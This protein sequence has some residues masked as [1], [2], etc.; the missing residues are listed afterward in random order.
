MKSKGQAGF[1]LSMAT[2]SSPPTESRYMAALMCTVG[3]LFVETFDFPIGLEPLSVANLL[4]KSRLGGRAPGFVRSDC[5]SQPTPL[6]SCNCDLY[7]YQY[8]VLGVY[9]HR[10]AGEK[11]GLAPKPYISGVDVQDE[12]PHA[13]I[14]AQLDEDKEEE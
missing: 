12:V 1:G 11:L 6:A 2:I 7:C 3:R 4:I 8:L 10:V 13:T 5:G 9:L 14:E